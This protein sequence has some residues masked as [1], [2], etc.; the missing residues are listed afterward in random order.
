MDYIFQNSKFY[1]K[2]FDKAEFVR[3]NYKMEPYELGI[4]IMSVGGEP[5]G[6]LPEVR[7]KIEEEWGCKVLEAMGNANMVRYYLVNIQSKMAC[8]LSVQIM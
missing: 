7:K 2:K 5:G 6:G 1:L 4:K 8:I 3:K